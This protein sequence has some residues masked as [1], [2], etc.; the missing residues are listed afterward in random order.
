[1]TLIGEQRAKVLDAQASTPLSTLARRLPSLLKFR[2]R[3]GVVIGRITP[4]RTFLLLVE[5]DV[6]SYLPDVHPPPSSCEMASGLP[7]FARSRSEGASL[8]T[9][10]EL[11]KRHEQAVHEE[12]TRNGSTIRSTLKSKI[13]W[14]N[15][16]SLRRKDTFGDFPIG[17]DP[18][19]QSNEAPVATSTWTLGPT[20]RSLI[21]RCFIVLLMDLKLWI[22]GFIYLSATR[23]DATG[24]S[25]PAPR[26]GGVPLIYWSLWLSIVW[27]MWF[28]LL[29]LTEWIPRLIKNHFLGR[30]TLTPSELR[31]WLH[32]L[33]GIHRYV[34]L[35]LE[36]I[37]L[38]ILWLYLILR[39]ISDS[40][41]NVNS[42][43]GA[44]VTARQLEP[45]ISVFSV[46]PAVTQAAFESATAVYDTLTRFLFVSI[47]CA[48]LLLGEK[49]F[50]QATAYSFHQATYADRLASSR[51]QVDVLAALLGPDSEIRGQEATQP[52]EISRA[53]S[54]AT[55]TSDQVKTIKTSVGAAI[56]H[57]LERAHTRLTDTVEEV[58]KRPYRDRHAT[59]LG[60]ACNKLRQHAGLLSEHDAKFSVL[61]AMKSE[62]EA[63]KVSLRAYAP[64]EFK[65]TRILFLPND[66]TFITS[67]AR[68]SSCPCY[69]AER[70]LLRPQ[71]LPSLLA[72]QEQTSLAAF[73]SLVR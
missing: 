28:I 7:F 18:A 31:K 73:P 23:P 21:Q 54:Q 53:D 36:S 63:K 8:P 58:V 19:S 22:P 20:A 43:I 49:I 57:W 14:R 12:H 46:P 64:M 34:T 70:A 72:S 33:I 32:Y 59:V 29:P 52:R 3:S 68:E 69:A 48:G 61:T 47:I 67:L 39:N 71:M 30:A 24:H 6:S 40:D 38:Y 62:E 10:A 65:L 15:S 55:I 35:F 2:I 16:W 45:S 42:G 1:M 9:E 17:D 60:K 37:L 25:S 5:K 44:T 56:D 41:S 26:F 66:H 4:L 51:W 27:T 11:H 13:L 50:I